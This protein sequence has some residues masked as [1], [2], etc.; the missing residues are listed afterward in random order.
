[1]IRI[2]IFA[3]LF[4]FVASAVPAAAQTDPALQT[5]VWVLIDTYLRT[6]PK[7]S[8]LN[9][10]AALANWA[11]LKG[12]GLPELRVQQP[13]AQGAWS[14]IWQPLDR[15][16]AEHK[17]SK[18][19]PM[20]ALDLW[21]QNQD[22]PVRFVRVLGKRGL[23]DPKKPAER[24]RGEA[25]MEAISQVRGQLSPIRCN[26]RFEKNGWSYTAS[27]SLEPADRYVRL[28]LRGSQPCQTTGSVRVVNLNLKGKFYEDPKSAS[29]IKMQIL[30]QQFQSQG[31]DIKLRG[32]VDS[33][34]P[35]AG[36][37]EAKVSISL[38]IKVLDENVTGR[39]QLD[40]V[41]RQTGLALVTGRAIY[42]IRGKVNSKGELEVAL[43]PVSS[44]GGKPV[45]QLLEKEGALTGKLAHGTVS[46]KI[47]LPVLKNTPGWSATSDTSR[48]HR[49][50]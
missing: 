14:A 15:V 28:A 45:R 22:S 18:L 36:G 38:D 39:F 50:R 4:L 48:L 32:R 5:G 30:D 3:L 41:S 29:G 26:T 13:L 19:S 24:K 6:G 33:I 34:E 8:E 44:S 25:L 7:K 20:E 9:D 1:M 23:L 31:C 49:A 35:L 11:L 10:G 47:I 17:F 43:V 42:S 27:A 2:S 16:L 21:D 12:V 46:G 37:G 40:L